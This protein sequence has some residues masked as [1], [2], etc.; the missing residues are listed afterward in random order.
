MQIHLPFPTYCI[1]EC[2]QRVCK[3][4]CVCMR[5]PR[6]CQQQQF[7]LTLSWK[8]QITLCRLK[9][10]MILVT[11]LCCTPRRR[12]FSSVCVCVCMQVCLRVCMCVCVCVCGAGGGQSTHG[13]AKFPVSIGWS[14]WP[15]GHY[16]AGEEIKLC[17]LRPTWCKRAFHQFPRRAGHQEQQQ[18][19]RG[20]FELNKK[21]IGPERISYIV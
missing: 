14:R 6:R 4:V 13:L 2:Q 9:E 21:D 11:V 5:V 3:C 20:R 15:L 16:P 1:P 12:P 8:D 10:W 18:R 7:V 19:F 17:L